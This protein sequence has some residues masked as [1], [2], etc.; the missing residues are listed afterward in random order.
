[1]NYHLLTKK[2]LVAVALLS[3]APILAMAQLDEFHTTG[4]MPID[5][6]GKAV[7]QD[8]RP[9]AGVKVRA[10]I[11][12]VE[13]TAPTEGG[14]KL[15]KVDL[16]SDQNGDFSIVNAKGRSVQVLSVTKKGYEVSPK[17]VATYG[18]YPD[19]APRDPNSPVVFKMWKKQGA[20]PLAHLAWRGQITCDGQ[21]MSFELQEKAQTDYGQMQIACTRTPLV[22]PPP[23]SGQFDYKFEITVVGGGI[24][25]TEDEFMY[26]APESGYT[27]SFTIERKAGDTNWNGKVPQQYYVKTADGHYGKLTVDWSAAFGSP[28]PLRWECFVNPTGSRNLEYDKLAEIRKHSSHPQLIHSPDE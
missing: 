26:L 13:Q 1:M 14:V 16:E 9:L 24:H 8:G 23:G 4:N 21:P 3:L 6:Y 2:T 27:S 19:Q 5:F 15:D 22:S 12:R 25:T 28:T 11:M 17:A 7:D 20:Q 10:E 18:Y